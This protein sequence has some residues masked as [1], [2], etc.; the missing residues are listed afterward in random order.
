M[1]CWH[2]TL[3]GVDDDWKQSSQAIRNFYISRMDL[4][5]CCMDPNMWD[6]FASPEGAQTWEPKDL[7][8]H[9][10]ISFSICAAGAVWFVVLLGALP[11]FE[12]LLIS[13]WWA[14]WT[15]SQVDP[16]GLALYGGSGLACGEFLGFRCNRMYIDYESWYLSVSWEPNCRVWI[17][18]WSTC[19][20]CSDRVLGMCY[21]ISVV[22]RYSFLYSGP[23]LFLQ[24]CNGF[25]DLSCS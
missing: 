12:W 11:L 20:I 10:G 17:R 22:W 16:R 8:S 7:L 2:L 15:W 5:K 19:R 3:S 9:V 18:F 6:W 13:F 24:A 25:P 14:S 23:Q 21:K 4:R 1:S